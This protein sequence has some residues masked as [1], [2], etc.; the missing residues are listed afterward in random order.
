MSAIDR[1]V[2]LKGLVCGA[3]VTTVGLTAIPKIARSSTIGGLEGRRRKASEPGRR[4]A[5]RHYRPT[6]PPLPPPLALLVGTGS[7]RVWVSLVALP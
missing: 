4:H 6:P 3:A 5:G 2:V 1:R 7:S